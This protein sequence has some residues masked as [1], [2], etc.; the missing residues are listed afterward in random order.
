ML[1]MSTIDQ[2]QEWEETLNSKEGNVKFPVSFL[3]RLKK[4]DIN[5]EAININIG[6]PRLKK[7]SVKEIN[8]GKKNK[9]KGKQL[10]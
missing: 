7:S 5:I 6:T 9:N 3:E 8:L 10:F 2:T 1:E 4:E